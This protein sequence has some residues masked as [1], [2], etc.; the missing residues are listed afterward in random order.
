[1]RVLVTGIGDRGAVGVR[2]A[3]FLTGCRVQDRWRAQP[4]SKWEPCWEYGAFVDV[5][6]VAAAVH[7][8]LTVP[9]AGHHRMLLCAAGIAA[10]TPSLEL[11]TRLAPHVPV[12][13]P[14]RYRADPWAA[15]IDCSAA[16]TLGWRAAPQGG[17]IPAGRGAAA[18]LPR[19]SA[20]HARGRSPW[21]PTA[22][23]PP[24]CCATSAHDDALPPQLLA[25]GIP[26]CAV[27]TID[28]LAVVMIASTAHLS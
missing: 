5:R 24:T 10:T 3:G 1:M 20:R 19:R 27:T 25:V 14:D 23:S 22:G 17:I 6:D 16:T 26:P 21:S 15:F 13:D 7:R 11:A 18:G 9:L 2:V 8:A 4:R 12:T 28:G